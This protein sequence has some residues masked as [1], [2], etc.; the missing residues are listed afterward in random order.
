MVPLPLVPPLAFLFTSMAMMVS[1]LNCSL[2]LSYQKTICQGFT[3]QALV[4]GG[5]ERQWYILSL[6]IPMVL[7]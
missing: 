3:E 7:G 5:Y 2:S 6:S 4:D 1:L